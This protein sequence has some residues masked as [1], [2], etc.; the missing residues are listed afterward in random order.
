MSRTSC[1][2]AALVA[3]LF[4]AQGCIDYGDLATQGIDSVD[5]VA[6]ESELL[7]GGTDA[8]DDSMTA[9]QVATDAAARAAT[10]WQPAG[11]ITASARGA[12][13][14]YTLSDCTGPYG[15]VHVTGVVLVTYTRAADGLHFHARGVGV[16]VNGGSLDLDTDGVY[17]VSGTEKHVVATTHGSGVGPRGTS[18]SRDGQYDL[19]WDPSATCVAL[20]GSWSNHAGAIGWTTTVSGYRRCGATC[21]VAGG[22]IVVQSDRNA[23]T[24][25]FDGS[26]QASWAEERRG[27]SG[28]VQLFC[29]G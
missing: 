14:T 16:H 4:V 6:S 5:T 20:D 2:V 7:V 18:F 13:V 21:P 9:E 3:P 27:R 15:H 29:E 25:T 17:T 8:A 11:C 23:L 10:F 1:I 26:A 22:H 24:V 12:E 28:T 19:R